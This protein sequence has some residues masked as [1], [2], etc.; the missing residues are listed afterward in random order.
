ML[1]ALHEVGPCLVTE[2]GERAVRNELSWTNFANL[3]FVE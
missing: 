3:L 2:D 1:G